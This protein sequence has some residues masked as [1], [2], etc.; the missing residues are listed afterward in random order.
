MA[1]QR[2]L[3]IDQGTDITVELHLKEENGSPK[4]LSGHVLRGKI[5]K[6]YDTTDNDQ[7]FDWITSVN[8]PATAGIG[9][10]TLTSAV[11]DTMKSGRYVYDIEL[12]SGDATEIVER[13]LEGKINVTPSV[14]K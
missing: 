9:T 11:T 10:I 1:Q 13:I 5:K 14:T 7:I 3:K 6:N 12:V 4:N 8:S 2:D